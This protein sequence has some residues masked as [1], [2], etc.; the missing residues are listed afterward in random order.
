MTEKDVEILESIQK[1]CEKIAS[2]VNRF[3]NN[4]GMFDMDDDYKDSISMNIL[5]IGE[6][7]RKLSN[8]FSQE[9]KSDVDWS[10]ARAMRNLFAHAYDSMD[11]YVIWNTVQK[12][13]P[14][15][16]MFCKQQLQIAYDNNI[17]IKDDNNDDWDMEMK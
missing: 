9:S 15:L 11:S 10:S 5:Q 4:Y 6:L 12:D 7:S 17:G 1:Y 13:I 16:Y 3:G 14:K 8:E 2:T